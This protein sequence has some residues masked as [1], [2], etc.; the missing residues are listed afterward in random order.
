IVFKTVDP[1]T[2]PLGVL[3]GALPASALITFVLIDDEGQPLPNVAVHFSR[4]ATSDPGIVIQ[5]N[6]ISDSSGT[7][8]TVLSTGTLPGPVTVIATAI[9]TNSQGQPVLDSNGN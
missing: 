9:V 7:V 1:S 2:T 8:T 3:G 4:N 5:P 6:K